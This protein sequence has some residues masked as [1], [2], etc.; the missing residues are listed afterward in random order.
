[1]HPTAKRLAAIPGVLVRADEP[2]RLALRAIELA[3]EH[4]WHDEQAN[5]LARRGRLALH[6]RR[7]TADASLDSELI[8]KSRDAIDWLSGVAVPE[9]FELVDQDDALLLQPVGQE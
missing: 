2:G 7:W 9:G 4:G 5:E 1:M 3:T 6:G 8:T